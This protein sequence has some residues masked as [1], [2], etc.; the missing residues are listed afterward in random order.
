[1][2]SPARILLLLAIVLLGPLACLK[3]NPLVEQL[4]DEAY[5]DGDETDDGTDADMPADGVC[6]AP[7]EFEPECGACLVDGCCT[8]LG[9]CSGDPV[10]VCLV[11]CLLMGGSDNQCRSECGAK[12]SDVDPVAPLMSCAM[13]DC[14]DCFSG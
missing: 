3:P 8:S 6:E 10:C 5:G 1:M 9:P 2:S 4:A 13:H 14:P 12:P 7:Q 11:D